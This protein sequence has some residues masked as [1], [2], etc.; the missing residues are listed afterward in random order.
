MKKIL[1]LFFSITLSFKFFAQED[2][3]LINE[4]RYLRLQKDSVHNSNKKGDST[5]RTYFYIYSGAAMPFNSFSQNNKAHNN[6]GKAI[7]G[8]NFKAG[9]AL[10]IG[11]KCTVSVDYDQN[12]LLA[13][14]DSL[15]EFLRTRSNLLTH[16]NVNR[17][18]NYPGKFRIITNTFGFGFSK[19][20]YFG[21]FS[22]QAKIIPSTGS[23]KY[24]Y[25]VETAIRS[26][27]TISGSVVTNHDPEN[28]NF[29]PVVF[30]TVRPELNFNYRVFKGKHLAIVVNGGISYFR[31]SPSLSLCET[32]E[33]SI[34]EKQVA[35]L[36]D[37]LIIINTY[38]GINFVLRKTRKY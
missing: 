38:C 25:R 12:S 34:F 32:T 7:T 4:K 20:F 37:K 28:Y 6:F 19:I 31:I 13:T 29:K 21:N 11:S 33:T 23:I 36:K 3:T 17:D 15:S 5:S 8:S 18:V 24:G 27:T 26:Y 22:V 14:N 2:T 35:G 16:G 10:Y 9:I 1:F 30:Y